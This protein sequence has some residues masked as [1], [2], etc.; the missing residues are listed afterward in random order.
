LY[1]SNHLDVQTRAALQTALAEFDGSVLLVSHDRQLLRTT[2]DDFWIVAD[3]SVTEF[4][5]DLDDYRQW[6][7]QRNASLRAPAA[8]SDAAPDRKAQ[9]RQEAE[10]RQA[11]SAQRKPIERHIANIER[12]MDALRT[13]LDI[14]NTHIA[15]PDFYTEAK[16]SERQSVM[17]EHGQTQKALNALE[18]Q[19]LEAQERLEALEKSSTLEN[20]H[21]KETPA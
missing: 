17:E 6:L 13:R 5:G 11:L 18:E 4:D 3:G 10:A 7:A 12:E 2:V 20:P 21:S 15:D 9:R 14:L 19:W 8:A 16:G 1:F